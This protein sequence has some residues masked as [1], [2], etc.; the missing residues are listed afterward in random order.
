[1]KNS[2]KGEKQNKNKND[3]QKRS[4]Q[5][6]QPEFG[7][8]AQIEFLDSFMSAIVNYGAQ[9]DARTHQKS[10]PKQVQ[11][12]S[13]NIAK[14]DIFLMCK[15]MRTLCKNIGLVGCVRELKKYQ[16]IIKNEIKNQ[17]NRDSK[18]IEKSIGF[19]V[20]IKQHLLMER[21]PNGQNGAPEQ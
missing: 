5:G 14:I 12:K 11:K 6:C 18:N 15:D 16:T 19:S 10:M 13:M 20:K 4:V 21:P 3:V 2:Q 7:Y 17:A 9:I 1:M 8:S